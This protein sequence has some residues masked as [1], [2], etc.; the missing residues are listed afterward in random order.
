MNPNKFGLVDILAIVGLAIACYCMY[1]NDPAGKH[2]SEYAQYMSENLKFGFLV[3]AILVGS[4]FLLYFVGKLFRGKVITDKA[5]WQFRSFMVY[6]GSACLGAVSFF[7]AI[8][9][10]FVYGVLSP[11]V[12][13]FSVI[14]VIG[15]LVIPAMTTFVRGMAAD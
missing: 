15:L 10:S 6:I 8:V 2:G 5:T 9:L 14:G 11:S 12:T 13:I 7:I 3:V 1:F 4:F